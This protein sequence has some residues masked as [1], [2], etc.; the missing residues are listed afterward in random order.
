MQ[1]VSSFC[2]IF[3]LNHHN[4]EAVQIKS[5]ITA[6]IVRKVS[7]NICVTE[8]KRDISMKNKNDL[9]IYHNIKE[10]KKTHIAKNWNKFKQLLYIDVFDERQLSHVAEL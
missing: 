6:Q 10:I 8:K 5:N 2:M 1:C 7:E 4:M 9:A 3:L